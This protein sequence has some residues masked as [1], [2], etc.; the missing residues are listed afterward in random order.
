MKAKFW[1][2]ALALVL[3]LGLLAGGAQALTAQQTVELLEKYYV[4]P[5]PEAVYGQ[6]TV[7]GVLEALGDPYTDYF[8]AEEYE[9]FLNSMLDTSVVGIGVVVQVDAAGVLVVEVLEGGPAEEAGLLAGDVITAVDGKTTVGLALDAAGELLRGQTGS[10]LT[11]TVLRNWQELTFP[12]TRRKVVV[13]ATT[14]EL[15][16]GH[17]GYIQCTTF[18]AET[19]RHFEEGITKYAAQA[20]RWIVDLRSNGGGMVD[21]SVQAVGCF[22]GPGRL[23]YLRAADGNYYYYES[24][25]TV[26]AGAPVV[27]LTDGQTASASEMFA[28]AVR[29]TG[30][31]LVIGTR[32]FG[33]G[34]AQYLLD[35][36]TEPDCF[37]DGDALK[38]TVYRFF[39]PNFAATDR[40][41]VIP[42]L[43]ISDENAPA[44]AVLL[45]AAPP[46]WDTA[47]FLRLELAGEWYID[48]NQAASEEYRA[49]FTELLEAIPTSAVLSLGTGENWIG[50]SPAMAATYYDLAD[51]TPREFLDTGLSPYAEEIGLLKTYGV[52]N[53]AGDGKFYPAND[54]TRGELCQMAVNAL[55]CAAGN[56]DAFA[57]VPG[58]EWF[59][60]AVNAACAAGLVNGTPGGNFYPNGWLTHQEL[61]TILGRAATGLSAEFYE[62]VRQ[63]EG[64][65][66]GTSEG[67]AAYAD[68]AQ[69]YVWLL[70][71]SQRSE[72]GTVSLLWDDLAAIDPAAHA[73]REEAAALLCNILWYLDIL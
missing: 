72:E 42:D 24:T 64:Q 29:D 16:E 31:G 67:V 41:G 32:T 40:V 68:W 6:D 9:A 51:Y 1:S 59:A 71:E 52:V 3:C 53:G 25:E 2:R 17:V 55:R 13:P 20:D 10:Q 46:A 56:G 37:Q 43:L 54:L 21:D 12:M 8:T 35:A 47:G 65:K 34:V 19:P 69:P 30:A 23:A 28:S 45:C 70:A 22:T 7:E 62:S 63:W 44:A 5:I 33:K 61:I 18:G 11:V 36:D 4:D 39:S 26:R 14:T 49:A 48:A 27:V 57:D 50:I 58:G 38:L 60:D 15:L 73:T 66:D